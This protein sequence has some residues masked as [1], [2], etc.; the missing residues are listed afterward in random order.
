MDINELT[1]REFT[2]GQTTRKKNKM[3]QKKVKKIIK[4]RDLKPAKDTKGGRG[5]NQVDGFGGRRVQ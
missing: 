2:D 1:R 4:V 5:R 3:P